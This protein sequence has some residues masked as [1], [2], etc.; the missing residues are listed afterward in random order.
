ME[1]QL[2]TLLRWAARKERAERPEGQQQYDV[3]V[4][5]LDFLIGGTVIS[6]LMDPLEDDQA[7]L[8]EITWGAFRGE[9]ARFPVFGY[10][11]FRMR[12]L[13]LD[14]A[15]ALNGLPS[16]GKTFYRGGYRAAW[17]STAG[18][19]VPQRGDIVYL[20]MAGLYHLPRESMPIITA[21]L[22]YLRELTRA[23][24][25]IADH[26]FDVPNVNV[27]L[28]ESLKATGI[29]EQVLPWAA[30]I[31][32]HEWPGMNVH[33]QPA[34][35]DVSGALGLLRE[36]NFNT[37]DEYLNGITVVTTPQ[38]P[39]TVLEYRDPRALVRA[40]SHFDVTCELV[41]GQPLI[42]KPAMDRSAL[43]VQE[44]QSHSD[45]QS[46]MSALGEVI[47]ELQVPKSGKDP[48]YATGRLLAWLAGQL[49]KIDQ[50]RVQ[51]AIHLLNAVR[52]IRNSG[53]HPKPKK[54]LIEAHNRLGLPFPIQDPGNAWDIV[55]AQMDTAFGT[56][57]E[58]IL[59]AR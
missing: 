33:R 25:V 43:L 12:Q 13:G 27:G 23:Q 32:E 18:G 28:A 42:K 15:S 37:I 52:A 9:D 19:G 11:D 58:E 35:N 44:A 38:Q 16:I 21:L 54:E 22:A 8:L 36:A 48:N 45:F 10:V 31:A 56:L 53:Q 46:G 3:R 30:A 17:C 6:I 7:K 39:T 51:D 41:L 40:I 24:E 59:A 4:T 29:D 55:R 5:V 57:Q 14:A 50:M 26:P 1:A 34:T 47:G 20:T 2:V 49:P